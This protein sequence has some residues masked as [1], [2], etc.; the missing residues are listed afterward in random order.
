MQ[1]LLSPPQSWREL[2]AW[3]VAMFIAYS[4]V[5]WVK[6]FLERKKPR[7]DVHETEARAELTFAQAEAVRFTTKKNYADLVE[8]LTVELGET[9][10]QLRQA[11]EKIKR[12]D[13]QI[14]ALEDQIEMIK[15]GKIFD[16]NESAG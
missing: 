5:R 3:I 10:F 7:A 4:G 14:H 13:E 1:S 11:E 15:A 6:A 9:N 8:E 16:R 12:R 2:F